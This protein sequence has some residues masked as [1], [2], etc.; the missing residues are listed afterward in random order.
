[1]VLDAPDATEAPVIHQTEEGFI[2]FLGAP[3][4]GHF[5]ARDDGNKSGGASAVAQIFLEDH[6]AAFGVISSS[7][8]F[9]E[10]NTQNYQG[11]DFVRLNQ[12]YNDIPVY[13]AQVV[14]QVGAGPA[15][16]GRPARPAW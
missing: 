6:G 2:R 12:F 4:G 14:V 10:A 1:M 11:A 8:A 15:R 13:G 7:T 3:P 9:Q 5:V 16:R